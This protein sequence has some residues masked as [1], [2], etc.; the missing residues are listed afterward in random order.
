MMDMAQRIELT[1]EDGYK[2]V[3]LHRK[4]S[5]SKGAVLFLH[6]MPATKESWDDFAEQLLQ[7]GISSLAIDLRGHGESV[8]KGGERFDY[9]EFEDEEHQASRQ[10]VETAASWLKGQ[11]GVNDRKL[12]VVGASIGSNLAIRHAYEHEDLLAAIA[13]SPGIDYHGV[14]TEDAVAGLKPHQH[15]LIA[16]STED[17]LSH[18]SVKKLEVAGSPG[19]VKYVYLEAAGHGTTMFEKDPGFMQETL[20]WLMER[21]V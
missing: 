1:T 7:K 17:K 20:D 12:A 9:R 14:L 6:M 11:E 8:M 10:D 18:M 5:D 2:V 4:A 16:V 15:L 21:F 13:L 3:G 19:K